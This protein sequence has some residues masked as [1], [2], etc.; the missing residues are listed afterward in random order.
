MGRKSRKNGPYFYILAP[1]IE[2]ANDFARL[3]GIRGHEWLGV[4]TVEDFRGIDGTGKLLMVVA[5]DALEHRPHY[6]ALINSD[7]LRALVTEWAYRGGSHVTV[8]F[9]EANSERLTV[10]IAA[11]RGEAYQK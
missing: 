4:R 8:R 2:I 5:P 3:N 9:S 11:T 6:D 7:W 1:T 10:L